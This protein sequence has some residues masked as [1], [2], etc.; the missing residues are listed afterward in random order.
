MRLWSS[1]MRLR[2]F[3]VRRETREE[4]V[5]GRANIS[6]R[7]ANTRFLKNTHSIISLSKNYRLNYTTPLLRLTVRLPHWCPDIRWDE[8]AVGRW[9]PW[10]W[11]APAGWSQP[12]VPL[13]EEALPS[14]IYN[15]QRQE[16]EINSSE[17]TVR[18][19]NPATHLITAKT[20]F[21]LSINARITL[22]QLSIN[23]KNIFKCKHCNSLDMS[24]ITSHSDT[25]IS[26]LWGIYTNLPLLKTN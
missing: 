9:T 13:T 25:A 4:G 12:S 3:S 5:C 10:S 16:S 11:P 17:S 26:L 22:V 7:T 8:W 2:S 14:D 24:I 23:N 18:S 21:R 1:R 20:K 6:C 15:S 19:D